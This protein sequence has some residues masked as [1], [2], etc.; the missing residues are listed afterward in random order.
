[1]KYLKGEHE[2]V[3]EENKYGGLYKKDSY[4]LSNS[5]YKNRML[6]YELEQKASNPVL[7]Y[8]NKK[9]WAKKMATTHRK[10][11]IQFSSIFL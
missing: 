2:E 7:A 10:Q 8:Q 4:K 1:M 3:Y 9:K 11:P 5:D 6:L